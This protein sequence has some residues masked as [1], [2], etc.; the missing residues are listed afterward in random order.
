MKVTLNSLCHFFFIFQVAA[1][2]NGNPISDLKP[3]Q[4]G[5][6]WKVPAMLITSK[7][8]PI[9]IMLNE[10]LQ[11]LR[12]SGTFTLMMERYLQRH[13]DSYICIFSS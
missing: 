11:R 13:S 1:Y 10:G 9:T 12:Q 7:N 5:S 8:S 3:T 6:K 4:V 2:L